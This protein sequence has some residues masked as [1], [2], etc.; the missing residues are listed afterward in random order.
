VA[1]SAI[2]NTGDEARR[3]DADL[4]ADTAS[5]EKASGSGFP[6]RGRKKPVVL[7]VAA[8]ALLALAVSLARWAGYQSSHVI[9]RNAIV[10]GQ[11][12]EVGTRL[13]GVLVAIEAREGERVKA[14]QVLA[15]LDDRHLRSDVLEAQAQI[16]SLERELELE[17]STVKHE[18]RKREMH[19]V[20]TMAKSAAARAEMVAAQSRAQ[21]ARD[22]RDIRQ[23]LVERKMISPE[24]M[25]EAE[26]KYRTAQA[27][28]D[29][30][31]GNEAAARSSE[32][33]AR[34]DSDG[35][36]LREQHVGVLMAN[37]QAAKARLARAQADIES[38]LVRAPGDGA[39]IRWLIK[40]GGSVEIGKP[41]V[42]MSIGRDV[43][44][45]AWIDEDEIGR[46]KVGSPATVTLSSHPGREFSG[47]V[48]T[49]GV[50]T[51]FEQAPADVPQPRFERMR[52]A[53]MVGVLV[54]LHDTPETLLPGL[55]AVVAIRGGDR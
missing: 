34:I 35:V 41:V 30:A 32:L 21:E 54:R 20:E 7:A 47:T 24:A 23:S 4:I 53:P 29:V 25:R 18:R 27:L 15:R 28:V 8:L 48:D 2:P 1:I 10:R 14:G 44:I 39:I 42:S 16:E 9:S 40:P 55:S 33:N 19:I 22:Y 45:E 37:V 3:K 13:D 38:S 49:I 46:V 17:H 51:D 11:L 6:W 12:T 50:A 31:W 36:K 26:A 52:G 5:G 43:A